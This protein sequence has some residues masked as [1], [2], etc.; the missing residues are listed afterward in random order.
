MNSDYDAAMEA[1]AR[2]LA[3]AAH[4]ALLQTTKNDE[5]EA[6]FGD[7]LRHIDRAKVVR[8]LVATWQSGIP[9][10]AGCVLVPGESAVYEG[11]ATADSGT[12]A[13]ARLPL[14][15]LGLDLTPV[16]ERWPAALA[17]ATHLFMHYSCLSR[18]QQRDVMAAAGSSASQLRCIATH[19]R[20][21]ELRR[22][23]GTG[24][25]LM[26]SVTNSVEVFTRTAPLYVYAKARRVERRKVWPNKLPE[27]DR[28][29]LA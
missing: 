15:E 12:P 26:C 20:P 17:D 5:R 28:S 25:A 2:T 21:I 10:D 16:H 9:A 4:T 6:S 11:T 14:Q 27:C 8:K 22:L 29:D 19:A 13:H 23:N 18:G 24:F 3:N 7:A 1:G